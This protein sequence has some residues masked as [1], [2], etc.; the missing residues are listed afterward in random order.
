MKQLVFWNIFV[1]VSPADIFGGH[2]SSFKAGRLKLWMQPRLTRRPRRLIFVS[3]FEPAHFVPYPLWKTL[4][5]WRPASVASEAIKLYALFE[6]VKKLLEGSVFRGRDW[7][8]K[9]LSD[10]DFGGPGDLR[11]DLQG[12]LRPKFAKTWLY[13][14]QLLPTWG[15]SRPRPTSKAYQT[16]WGRS[17]G[18]DLQECGG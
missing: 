11:S 3:L 4:G 17:L 18:S 1:L 9:L 6:G 14:L 10:L 8:W 12:H 15:H 16:L 2:F 7:S 13:P 5:H